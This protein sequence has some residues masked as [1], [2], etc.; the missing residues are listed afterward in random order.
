LEEQVLQLTSGSVG[1]S[2]FVDLEAKDTSLADCLFQLLGGN[3]VPV[4]SRRVAQIGDRASGGGDRNASP[5]GD[6]A[7]FKCPRAVETEVAAALS[8]ADT[9]NGYVDRT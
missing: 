8:P 5:F 9:G 1:F 4:M 7:W 3:R 2:W 6:V